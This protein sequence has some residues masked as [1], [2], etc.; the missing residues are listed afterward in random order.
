MTRGSNPGTGQVDFERIKEA[1]KKKFK[2]RNCCY[3]LKATMKNQ[4]WP[5]DDISCKKIPINVAG[6]D[7][8][9]TIF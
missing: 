8:Y 2:P 7:K 1:Q 3:S 9:T 4:G 6:K 5:E